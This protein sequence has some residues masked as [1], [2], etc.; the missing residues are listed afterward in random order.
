MAVVKMWFSRWPW[1]R[2]PSHSPHLL[3]GWSQVAF[4]ETGLQSPAE[5]P[6]L[7]EQ[8]KV[9]VEDTQ[10]TIQAPSENVCRSHTSAALAFNGCS[11]GDPEMGA[12][13]H[14]FL[15]S[16]P[17]HVMKEKERR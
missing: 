3:Q 17:D 11:L 12:S 7:P 5:E 2:F 13:F 10:L 1:V 16:Q 15:T 14:D 8:P 6:S 9:S 4:A